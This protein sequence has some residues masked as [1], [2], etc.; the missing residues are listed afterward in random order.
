MAARSRPELVHLGWRANGDSFDVALAVNRLLARGA[1]AW[2]LS[3]S[4]PPADAGDY[5]LELAPSQQRALAGFG[6]RGTP[7]S[8]SLGDAQLLQPPAVRLFAGKASKFPYFAYYALALLRLGIDYVPC[9]GATLASGT[10]DDA[11][12]LVLPGGFATWGIDAAEDAPGADARV[13]AFLSTG[14]T[15]IGSCGGAY[16]LS[17]GRPAWTGTAA[18]KPLYTH[19]YLQSGVG[20][21]TLAL[22]PGPLAFGCPRTI[23][24]PY[25]HGPIYDPPEL[26]GA[27]IEVAATFESLSLPGRLGI[28]NPLDHDRF[29]RDMQGKPAILYAA[30]DRGRAVLFS[31]HPEMGDLIRKYIA[32]DGYVRRYLPIRG[33]GT[34][35]DTLR[36]YRVT[37]APS[38]RLVLN[39]VHELMTHARSS[40]PPEL[41][42]SGWSERSL[43]EAARQA[44]A[45]LPPPGPGEEGALLAEI[46]AWIAARIEP[47]AA[48]SAEVTKHR[49][50]L[51][52]LRPAYD[53]LLATTASQAGETRERTPAQAL[54][55]L[56]LEVSL[57]ECWTR[58][59]EIDLALAECA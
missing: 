21:V 13:R 16:Y 1:R 36:H 48:R 35:R 4:R 50:R 3:A 25:Y 17:A 45:A 33:Y 47:L 49:A 12:I 5:L 56:E 9:D 15:A 44:L 57:L 18:A 7:W 22:Q 14:G 53:H 43:T 41:G 38:F 20:V 24:V 28:D 11:N 58:V 31:P 19:E 32:L 54:M 46:T 6:A 26:L 30:G 29:V 39:A 37:D 59:A 51:G 10:L 55:E 40:H 34:M 2:R 8:A 42:A 23:E 52:R 27:E